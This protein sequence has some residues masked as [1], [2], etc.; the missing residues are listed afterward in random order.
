MDNEIKEYIKNRTLFNECDLIII[1]P[2]FENDGIIIG[3]YYK[4]YSNS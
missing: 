3:Y 1:S 4:Y 2:K